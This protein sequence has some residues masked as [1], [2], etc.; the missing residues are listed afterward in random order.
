MRLLLSLI[1]LFLIAA[2]MTVEA[3]TADSVSTALP[4][5]V[6]TPVDID[7]DKPV[8]PAL[9]YYDKHGNPMQTPVK[10]LADLDTVTVEVKAS[11]KYP[12]FNGVS[13]GLN[14]FDAVL[15]IA[16]QR[17]ANLNLWADCSIR[18]WFFPVV[19]A[20]IGFSNARPDAGRFHFKTK[21][22]FFAKVGMN[23]NFLYKSNPDYQVYI[24]LRAGWSSFT[25]DILDIQPGSEYYSESGPTSV[26]GLRSNAIFGEVLAGVKVKIYKFFSMGWS[27]GYNFN[28]YQKYS[29]PEYPAWFTPGKGAGTPINATFSLIF[30]I[31]GHRQ[32]SI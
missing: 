10:F 8:Q 12:A 28:L 31:P 23:Y 20:G 27:I 3:Q 18:N 7:R 21:P 14:F 15:M 6:V 19:E 13:L 9:H 17:R 30:T 32:S 16:G 4:K 2:P 5:P 11:P 1:A 29:V 24:G 25:Y 22:Q 26:S